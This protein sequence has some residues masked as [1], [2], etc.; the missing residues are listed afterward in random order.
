MLFAA[1]TRWLFSAVL[2][3]ALLPAWCCCVAAATPAEGAPGSHCASAPTPEPVCPMHAPADQREDLPPHEV[4]ACGCQHGLMAG[5]DEPHVLPVATATALDPVISSPVF[6]GL[7]PEPPI[8]VRPI[9]FLFSLSPPAAP[10]LRT[11]G[12]LLTI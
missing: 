1:T 9:D 8:V 5:A 11:L 4:P 3:V 10:T 7:L 12:V 6:V 2:A